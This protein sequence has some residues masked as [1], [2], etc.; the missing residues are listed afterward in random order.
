MQKIIIFTSSG[1]GGH[2]SASNA[3]A[4]YLKDQYEVIQI[5]LL[6]EV[7]SSFDPALIASLGKKRGEEVYNR[8]TPYNQWWLLNFIYRI[9]KIYFGP[10]APF[11]RTKVIQHLKEHN[12]DMVISVIP[13]F[14][15][16]ILNAAQD[17]Q[18]PF[19]MMPT[20]LDIRSFVYNIRYPYYNKFHLSLIFDDPAI[21]RPAKFSGINE[22]HI[23]INGFPLRPE[24]FEE[25]DRNSLRNSMNIEPSRHVVMIMM[26]SQ[27]TN[28]IIACVKSLKKLETPIHLFVCIG[29]HTA[30]KDTLKNLALPPWVTLDIIEQTDQI[31]D[32]MAAAD[33]L[34]SK[35]GS[36]SF[37]EAIHMKLP[38]IIDGTSSG[39]IWERFN[40][41]FTKKNNLGSVIA[42][43]KQLP[44][45]ISQFFSSPDIAHEIK[46]N[47]GRLNNI[48]TPD[49]IRSRIARMLRKN[50]VFTNFVLTYG[51]KTRL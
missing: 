9:G 17:L 20:D 46:N 43:Y 3:L 34:I 48:R 22:H 30:I 49:R 37:C 32:Y 11:M 25:K 33:L 31:S 35:A 26:G 6:D 8:L 36:A 23:S 14:N 12:A 40:F 18:I 15:K 47:L 10:L 29:K 24:F 5:K 39:L 51:K 2:M 28:S 42:N 7:L 27:G 50:Y 4:Y 1:G 21:K 45:K 16:I 44:T 41:R 19:L 13:I 38:L